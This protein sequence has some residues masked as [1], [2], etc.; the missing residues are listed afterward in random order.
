MVG[1]VEIGRKSIL[2]IAKGTHNAAS[3]CVDDSIRLKGFRC[4]AAE[5]WIYGFRR[6][7]DRVNKESRE[8]II[9]PQ[10]IKLIE[11]SLNVRCGISEEMILIFSPCFFIVNKATE[12]G[13]YLKFN[14]RS[15]RILESITF[16]YTSRLQP[17]E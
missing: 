6:T 12:K 4:F 16:D 17:R 9:S 5:I 7:I 14:P 2:Y 15:G 1:G 11:I 13:N 10:K 8:F 3:R